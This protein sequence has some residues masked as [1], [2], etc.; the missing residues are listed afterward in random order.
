MT[1][2]ARVRATGDVHRSR[3]RI[4]PYYVWSAMR[5]LGLAGAIMFL[6]AIWGL[7][8]ETLSV[9]SAILIGTTGAFIGGGRR[10][11][12]LDVPI[13]C[14][15]LGLMLS[16][17]SCPECGQSVFDQMPATGFE[18]ESARHSFWPTRICY[19]CGRDT[20]KL[21]S[22]RHSAGDDKFGS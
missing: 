15:F 14:E 8:N 21:A 16:P 3:F 17:K 20:A 18:L 13:V 9:T 11:D 22:S 2:P 6:G 4:A 1:E 10:N 5:I 19:G 12:D 7:L